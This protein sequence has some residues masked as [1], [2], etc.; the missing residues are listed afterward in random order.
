MCKKK[1]AQ[2]FWAAFFI[3]HFLWKGGA[4]FYFL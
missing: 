3:P 1:A 2:K 4:G